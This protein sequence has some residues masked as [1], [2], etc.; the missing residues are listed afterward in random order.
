LK[1]TELMPPPLT[2]PVPSPLIVQSEAT[3]ELARATEGPSYVTG[4]VIAPWLT[5]TISESALT[6]KLEMLVGEW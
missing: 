6:S 2:V 1:E 4:A 3:G 5:S